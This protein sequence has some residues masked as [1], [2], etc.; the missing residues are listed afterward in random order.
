MCDFLVCVT[1]WGNIST[2]FRSRETFLFAIQ[3]RCMTMDAK[4]K[5]QD[6]DNTF[7]NSDTN[8]KIIHMRATQFHKGEWSQS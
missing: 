4:H 2:P 8:G 3:C 7:S 6:K 5:E 1:D